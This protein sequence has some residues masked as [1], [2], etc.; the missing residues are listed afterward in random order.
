M[1]MTAGVVSLVEVV[2]LVGV[3]PGVDQLTARGLRIRGPADRGSGKA[4]QL[5][6]RGEQGGGGRACWIAWTTT[7][8]QLYDGWELESPD[9][10]SA[11]P[12]R[13][14]LWLRR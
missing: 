8:T 9:V 10:L 3:E 6:S 14:A 4:S 5:A 11:G 12:L 13:R 1:G 7:P 2:S